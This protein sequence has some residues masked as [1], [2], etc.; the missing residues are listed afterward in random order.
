MNSTQP[1]SMLVRSGVSLPN[2]L[3]PNVAVPMPLQPREV[4]G[5]ESLERFA[6]LLASVRPLPIVS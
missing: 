1:I 5:V 4:R 6:K 2:M 3:F